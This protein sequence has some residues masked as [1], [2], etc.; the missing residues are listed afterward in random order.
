MGLL[1]EG[2]KVAGAT[3]VGGEGGWGSWRGV[4]MAGLLEGGLVVDGMEGV[5]FVRAVLAV[6]VPP[7]GGPPLP[8]PE[9]GGES[10][11]GSWRRGEGGWG[12]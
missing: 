6:A 3:G 1:Q 4:K 2:V 11:W 7:G 9:G 8:P 12:Y 10:G 5:V